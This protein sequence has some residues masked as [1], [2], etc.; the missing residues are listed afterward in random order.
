MFYLL[1]FYCKIYIQ[2]QQ[3][4]ARKRKIIVTGRDSQIYERDLVRFLDINVFKNKNQI[5]S[6]MHKFK[7]VLD[8]MRINRVVFES[9]T[10]FLFPIS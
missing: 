2:W 8:A 6:L 9:S 3:L 5:Q 7:A 4:L 1:H 10:F